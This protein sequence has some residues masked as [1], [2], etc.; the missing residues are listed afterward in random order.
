MQSHVH[1]M[2]CLNS[3]ITIVFLKPPQNVLGDAIYEGV[4]YT[5]YDFDNIGGKSDNFADLKSSKNTWCHH[6]YVKLTVIPKM[7]CA[8]NNPITSS[9]NIFRFL[10][11]T[12]GLFL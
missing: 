3:L 10:L 7:H 6:N 8:A 11:K 2:H 9:N 12:M 5:N 4:Q 1:K